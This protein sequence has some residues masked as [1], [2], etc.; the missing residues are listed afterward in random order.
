M[1]VRVPVKSIDQAFS[2]G[3]R[4]ASIQPEI[5]HVPG[6]GN[7][8]SRGGGGGEIFTRVREKSLE[9]VQSGQTLKNEGENKCFLREKIEINFS[10]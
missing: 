5:G 7:G 6:P 8:W 10:K 4:G 3:G 9:K 1:N 2:I